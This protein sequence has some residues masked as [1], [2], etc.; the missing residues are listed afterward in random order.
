MAEPAFKP[1][2]QVVLVKI[3]SHH[4]VWRIASVLRESE[5][6]GRIY[7]LE[8][9]KANRTADERDLAPAEKAQHA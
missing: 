7:L 6:L 5:R 1:G 4:K 9:G 3:G 2:D 8:D